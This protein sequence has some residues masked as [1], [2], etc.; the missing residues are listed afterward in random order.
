MKVRGVCDIAY[1]IPV[2][3][4]GMERF[5]QSIPLRL[6]RAHCSDLGISQAGDPHELIDRYY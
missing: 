5:L 2:M 3:L 1:M 4:R 6:L